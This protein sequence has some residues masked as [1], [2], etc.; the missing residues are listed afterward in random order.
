MKLTQDQLGQLLGLTFQQVQKYEKGMN[1]I[2]AGRLFEL[3]KALGVPVS[4]FF[5]GAE[6][7]LEPSAAALAENDEKAVAPVIGPDALELIAAFQRIKD[8]NLRKAL[9]QA[10]KAA[11]A[12]SDDK[13]G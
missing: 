6:D 11:A 1:R 13:E 7:L 10:I 5:D 9:F 2:S 12:A 3:G 8:E 4:Y